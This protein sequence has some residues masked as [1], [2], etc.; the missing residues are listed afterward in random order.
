MHERETLSRADRPRSAPPGGAR[1]RVAPVQELAAVLQ[2]TAG[3]AATGRVLQ[4][5]QL[6]DGTDTDFLTD[7]QLVNRFLETN[8]DEDDWVPMRDELLARQKMRAPQDP[9][10]EL[11]GKALRTWFFK[12]SS[13]GPA[14]D[15][16]PYEEVTRR[17]PPPANLFAA[18]YAGAKA[19]GPGLV[20]VPCAEVGDGDVY[21]QANPPHIE[22]DPA[23]QPLKDRKPR[24][25]PMCHI[26][27]YQHLLLAYDTIKGMPEAWRLPANAGDVKRVVW[28]PANLRP[29]HSVCN[30]KTASQGRSGAFA[31]GARNAAI[32]FVQAAL[33]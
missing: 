4:R 17:F 11:I 23:G 13:S 2:R 24:K 19:A 16:L 5:V 7:E 15:D 26:I 27:P 31:G 10:A 25:P 32:S 28:Q 18:V 3:N 12:G 29:G 6:S 33:V 20:S 8:E 30:A 22:T 14:T 21:F 1:A 9:A